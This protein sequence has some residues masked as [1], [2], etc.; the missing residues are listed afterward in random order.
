MEPKV[1]FPNETKAEILKSLEDAL[2]NSASQYNLSLHEVKNLFF[3]GLGEAEK[4]ED[5]YS[6][7]EG[8]L[9]SLEWHR[10]M[11]SKLSPEPWYEKIRGWIID[12]VKVV[13][14]GA[15]KGYLLRDHYSFFEEAKRHEHTKKTS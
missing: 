13:A 11:K 3:T 8:D 14:V 1:E 9:K 4:L 10:A 5:L 6:K 2:L 7:E 12:L 15:V